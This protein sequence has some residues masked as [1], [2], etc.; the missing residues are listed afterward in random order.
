MADDMR[1]SHMINTTQDFQAVLTACG[2]PPAM[3]PATSVMSAER[4]KRASVHAGG[5]LYTLASMGCCSALRAAA[6]FRRCT[7]ARRCTYTPAAL[8]SS[9]GKLCSYQVLP[10]DV[11]CAA[12]RRLA[13]GSTSTLQQLCIGGQGEIVT[14]D[15]AACC[16]RRRCSMPFREKGFSRLQERST[17]ARTT[18]TATTSA[19]R[20]SPACSEKMAQ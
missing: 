19:A 5:S 1:S 6:A 13:T 9:G 3:K 2:D 4:T 14:A 18:R 10:E 20:H 12:S 16:Q 7:C 11:P 15:A 8:F 17:R